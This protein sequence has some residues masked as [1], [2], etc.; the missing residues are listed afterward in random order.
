MEQVRYM[1]KDMVC[2]LIV[3]DMSFQ[4]LCSKLDNMGITVDID[5][6]M[7][8][9]LIYLTNDYYLLAELT[10]RIEDKS[11]DAEEAIEL[12]VDLVLE[13]YGLSDTV[14]N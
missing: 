8:K 13:K 7:Y 1:V 14:M 5:T 12:I 6:G 10:E 9:T 11:E 4:E 3:E 2:K